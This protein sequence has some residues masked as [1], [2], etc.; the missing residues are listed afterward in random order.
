MFLLYQ[1][2]TIGP[3]GI[4]LGSLLGENGHKHKF[5][6][7][8]GVPAF[9]S[10][11]VSGN[12]TVR[13]VSRIRDG[14]NILH[15][16]QRK[17]RSIFH[18]PPHS[19]GLYSVRIGPGIHHPHGSKDNNNGRKDRCSSLLAALLSHIATY[20]VKTVCCQPAN[21]DNLYNH[22]SSQSLFIRCVGGLAASNER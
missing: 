4:R 17:A 8:C 10:T 22:M 14:G 1:Q 18:L 19:L 6:H 12:F 13:N 9:S 7:S 11:F 15:L 2:E 5:R 21:T 3:L 16:K 20:S